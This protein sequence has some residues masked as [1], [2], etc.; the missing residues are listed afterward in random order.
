ME[1]HA[2]SVAKYSNRQNSYIQLKKRI[3]AAIN[4][5]QANG[6]IFR[7]RLKKPSH[8]LFSDME[9]QAQMLKQ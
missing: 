6:K 9:H 4:I 5:S 8:L 1:V 7:E 3:I 2:Q